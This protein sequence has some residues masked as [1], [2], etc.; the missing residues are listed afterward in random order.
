MLSPFAD[1]P[2]FINITKRSGSG[3]GIGFNNTVF[4]IEKIDVVAPIPR[5]SAATTVMV[6]PG[7]LKNIRIECL[8]SLKNAFITARSF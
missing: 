4:T 8:T 2:V 6:K 1:T 5:A 3:T 7:L